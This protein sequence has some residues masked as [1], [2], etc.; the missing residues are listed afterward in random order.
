LRRRLTPLD[1]ETKFLPIDKTLASAASYPP[2]QKTQG[3]GTRSF[4]TGKKNRSERTGHPPEHSAGKPVT[5]QIE[6]FIDVYPFL[7]W[8]L[9]AKE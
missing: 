3:R 6:D 8:Q 1:S 4:E 5:K 7:F 2:L 9:G